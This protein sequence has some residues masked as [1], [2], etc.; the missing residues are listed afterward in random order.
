MHA[1][2]NSITYSTSRGR[3]Q[4]SLPSRG[5]LRSRCPGYNNCPTPAVAASS[6]RREGSPCP[7]LCHLPRPGLPRAVPSGSDRVA[8]PASVTSSSLLLYF[9]CSI[10]AS[11]QSLL[12]KCSFISEYRLFCVLI[13]TFHMHLVVKKE[14]NIKISSMHRSIHIFLVFVMNGAL[15]FVSH[16][17]TKFSGPALRPLPLLPQSCSPAALLQSP[18]DGGCEPVTR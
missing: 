14:K 2:L 16:R 12:V 13:T 17:A 10:F 8:C 18:T 9:R 7:L 4:S 15:I 6:D 11:N 3:L 5:S 1:Y